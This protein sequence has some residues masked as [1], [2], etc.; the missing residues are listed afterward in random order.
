MKKIDITKASGSLVDTVKALG[1]EPLILMEGKR[2]VAVLLPTDGADLET[3]SLSFNPKFMEIIAASDASLRTG[4]SISHEEMGRR[5]GIEP[6]NGK[7]AGKRF[8]PKTKRR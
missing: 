6:A 2:P 5:L 8:G 3:V 7:P 4:R 1:N